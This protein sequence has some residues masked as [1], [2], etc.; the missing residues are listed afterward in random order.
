[1]IKELNDAGAQYCFPIDGW[2]CCNYT[3]RKTKS[4]IKAI[5]PDTANYMRFLMG[6]KWKKRPRKNLTP[7][8]IGVVNAVADIINLK[9]EKAPTV[10]GKGLSHL[11]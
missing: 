10:Q 1:M 3:K 11:K 4:G 8:D 7:P 6:K 9:N 2:L 5:F